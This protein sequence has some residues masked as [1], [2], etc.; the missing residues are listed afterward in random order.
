[1]AVRQQ[2]TTARRRGELKRK[3]AWQRLSPAIDAQRRVNAVRA[4]GDGTNADPLGPSDRRYAYL[5]QAHD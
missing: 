3:L 5:T 4:V 1:M 2:D